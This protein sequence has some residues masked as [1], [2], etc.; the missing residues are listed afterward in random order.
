MLHLDKILTILGQALPDYATE[1]WNE[2][3]A[4]LGAIP[5]FDSMTVLSVITLIEEQFSVCVDDDD[6]SA[7][8][9][10]TI[11]SLTRWVNTIQ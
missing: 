11:G 1:D 8:D 9:F 6:I 7:E 3:T 10:E 5:E 2:G 4:L